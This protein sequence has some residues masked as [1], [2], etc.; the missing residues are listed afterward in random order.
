[1]RACFGHVVTTSYD[2]PKDVR[3]MWDEHTALVKKRQRKTRKSSG[4]E[5]VLMT[6]RVGDS[7]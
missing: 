1:M 3:L 4:G 6:L 5:L 2:A 7:T